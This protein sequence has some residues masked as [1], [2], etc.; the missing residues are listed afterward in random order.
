[1]SRKLAVV[2]IALVTA[3]LLPG[4]QAVS[5]F[6]G[7]SSESDL[8]QHISQEEAQ[9]MMDE[10]DGIAI[11]D[12][13][14]ETE[15][16]SGHIPGAICI[17]NES[18]S[19]APLEQLPDPDQVILVYCRSGSRSKQA[20]EKLANIGYTNVYEFGGINSWKGEVVS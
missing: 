17:P 18:I 4:C 5:Q 14:T 2:C 19:T 13:R 10:D 1:M 8:Y 11:V 9:R 6:F 12:V 7:D 3:L 16:N 15:Y 20:S